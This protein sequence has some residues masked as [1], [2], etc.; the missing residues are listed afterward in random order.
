MSIPPQFHDQGGGPHMDHMLGDFQQ[1]EGANSLPHPHP[2]SNFGDTLSHRI[3][4]YP[5][6]VQ[7]EHLSCGSGLGE[8][9]SGSKSTC[10]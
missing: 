2:G 6:V 5:C 7:F 9:G 1:D 8:R 4:G 3:N 10:G